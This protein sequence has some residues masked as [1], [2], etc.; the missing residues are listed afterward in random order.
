MLVKLTASQSE[1]S[2]LLDI[3]LLMENAALPWVAAKLNHGVKPPPLS[4][5]NKNKINENCGI[6]LSKRELT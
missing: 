4:R 5:I 2:F 1:T 6:P 3:R